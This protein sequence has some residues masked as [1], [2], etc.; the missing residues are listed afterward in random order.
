MRRNV[1]M[2][3]QIGLSSPC[4]CTRASATIAAIT[5]SVPPI[6]PKK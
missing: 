6:I 5:S 3:P 2:P 1:E 4:F